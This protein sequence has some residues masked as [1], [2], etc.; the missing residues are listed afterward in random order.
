MKIIYRFHSINNEDSLAQLILSMSMSHSCE[1]FFV[2]LVEFKMQVALSIGAQLYHR[3]EWIGTTLDK[4]TTLILLTMT[5]GSSLLS[6]WASLRISTRDNLTVNARKTISA[7]FIMVVGVRSGSSRQ[8]VDATKIISPSGE[9][10][11]NELKFQQILIVTITTDGHRKKK[12]KIYRKKLWK[13]E[14]IE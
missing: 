4:Y 12:K 3:Y 13:C 11:S 1:Y 2:I 14:E 8:R 5:T 6:C 9:N 7:G 10:Y